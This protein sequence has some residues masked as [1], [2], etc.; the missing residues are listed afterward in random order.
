MKFPFSRYS[1]ILLSLLIFT[2]IYAEGQV[3]VVVPSNRNGDVKVNQSALPVQE[4]GGLSSKTRI[5]AM[6]EPKDLFVLSGKPDEEISRQV[7]FFCS[8]PNSRV[9]PSSRFDTKAVGAIS[10]GAAESAPCY[11][12]KPFI[13]IGFIN[14]TPELKQVVKEVIAEWTTFANVGFIVD[15]NSNYTGDSADIKILFGANSHNSYVGIDA[16]TEF[17]RNQGKTHPTM[18]LGY[19]NSQLRSSDGRILPWVKGTVL[20]EFGHALGLQHEH[21]NPAGGIQW[22]REAVIK[23]LGGPPNNWNNEIIENNI[24][25]ALS[26]NKTQFTQYDRS[27]IMHYSFPASWT[28]NGVAV[29][30]NNELSET[31]KAFVS[32][33][34]PRKKALLDTTQYYRL[35]TWYNNRQNCLGLAS[36]TDA[37]GKTYFPYFTACDNNSGAQLW[38]FTRLTSGDYRVTN[39]VTGD[40]LALNDFGLDYYSGMNWSGNYSNQYWTITSLDKYYRLSSALNGVYYSLSADTAPNTKTYMSRTAHWSNQLWEFVP[41]GKIR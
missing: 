14:G 28:L 7:N 3:T 5:Q 21:Q 34:Y 23:D 19:L 15:D 36:T 39:Y 26:R 33:V 6:T 1:F 8:T 31:D 9:K 18:N 41:A 35:T 29:P 10:C 4:S 12:T 25:R 40:Q 30:D 11:W 17:V 16:W 13:F 20:H 24:F 22:N 32:T 37:S 38:K 27:S 2:A